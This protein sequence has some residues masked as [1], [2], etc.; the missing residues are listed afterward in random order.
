MRDKT[1]KEKT[2]MIKNLMP[3]QNFLKRNLIDVFN[4]FEDLS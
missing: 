4:Q 3:A 2:D 1:P